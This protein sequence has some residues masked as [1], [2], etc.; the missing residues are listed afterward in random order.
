MNLRLIAAL[1]VLPS[2]VGRMHP[3]T[4]LLVI[5]GSKCCQPG[6]TRVKS[7]PVVCQAIRMG[8]LLS[9]RC[10]RVHDAGPL[11]HFVRV[12]LTAAFATDS[13]LCRASHRF[14]LGTQQNA[15][16]VNDILPR[17]HPIVMV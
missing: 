7:S 2:R 4:Q 8:Q 6:S 1:R 14:S 9:G 16:I 12:Y 13:G 5:K 3:V 17:H 10:C 15:D 11:C